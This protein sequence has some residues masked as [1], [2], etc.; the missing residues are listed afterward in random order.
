MKRVLSA[1]AVAAAFAAIPLMTS[2]VAKASP[3][4]KTTGSILMSGGAGEPTQYASFDAFQSNPVKGSISYTN[5]DPAYK[6]PGTGVWVPTNFNMS[7]AINPSTSRGATYA[8]TT[9]SFTPTSPTSVTF[10]GTGYVTPD[11]SWKAT[12][13]GTIDSSAFTLAMTEINAAN[14]TET[15]SLH[16]SG[17]VA[18]GGSISGPTAT[19]KDNYGGGRTG[20][21]AVDNVGYEA[22]HYSVPVT[23]ATVVSPADA[24]YT[25][26]IAG[27]N[28]SLDGTTI[29][30]H[31][32]DG[33]QPGAGHDTWGFSLTP[34]SYQNQVISGGN[35]TVFS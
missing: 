2:G 4:P 19:W 32:H 20:T 33:G 18:P 3:A 15:Y 1:L 21:F 7:F 6:T 10:T 35:L 28:T 30:V 16:A 23:D 26:A 14:P 25:Y 9:T 29:Y 24:Y 17:T 13:T 27:T 5:F 31:V 12:F 22:F 34:G 8:M 11:A